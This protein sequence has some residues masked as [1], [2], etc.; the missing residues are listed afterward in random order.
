MPISLLNTLL[1]Q[2]QPK[3][4]PIDQNSWAELD[5]L[6]V[7]EHSRLY[8]PTPDSYVFEGPTAIAKGSE[9]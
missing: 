8:R 9:R 1:T 5:S 3:E 7:P 4:Q 2:G 6:A